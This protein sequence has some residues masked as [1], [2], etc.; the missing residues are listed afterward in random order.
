MKKTEF[1]QNHCSMLHP[2]ENSMARIFPVCPDEI[3]ELEEPRLTTTGNVTVF[4][5]QWN[6]AS[7]TE[8]SSGCYIIRFS[9][10]GYWSF[11]NFFDVTVVTVAFKSLK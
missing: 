7:W 4:F 11:F 3:A 1:L 5:E 10:I 9:D 8:R 2:V 6:A